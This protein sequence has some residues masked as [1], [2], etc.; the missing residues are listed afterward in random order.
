MDWDRILHLNKLLSHPKLLIIGG[1]PRCGKSTLAHEIM[2]TYGI[3]AVSG[4]AIRRVLA[5]T[6]MSFLPIDPDTWATD[7]CGFVQA[8]RDRDSKVARACS[9]YAEQMLS[10]CKSIIVEG[11][12]W[13]DAI[14]HFAHPVRPRNGA[15]HP[16]HPEILAVYLFNTTS[17]EEEL[18]S[19]HEQC[20]DPTSWL[21]RYTADQLDG[22][23][24]A[25]R[26]R[27]RKMKQVVCEQGAVPIENERSIAK[28]LLGNYASDPSNSQA[29][30]HQ[31]C[32]QTYLDAGLLEGGL[33][34]M[35]RLA[36]E[37]IKAWMAP[38]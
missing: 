6:R 28:A 13:A 31:N 21:N 27:T 11:C 8:C 32:I 19:L 33:D 15:T 4:D 36:L 30:D 38:R 9:V 34:E 18:E 17:P 7:A 14:K 26:L 5:S 3:D 12:I 24:V 23:A 29:A 20:K 37:I 25:N 22:F 2:L 16:V 35:H 1:P 10:D